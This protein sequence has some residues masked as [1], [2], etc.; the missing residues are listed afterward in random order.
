M[1]TQQQVRDLI[2]HYNKSEQGNDPIACQTRVA[3]CEYAAMIEEHRQVTEM[4]RA[5]IEIMAERKR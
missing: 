4:F 2:P 3:L 5:S 1:M